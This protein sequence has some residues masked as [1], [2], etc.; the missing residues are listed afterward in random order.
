M[1][2]G[3]IVLLLWTFLIVAVAVLMLGFFGRD[4]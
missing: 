2:G 4:E 1:S 3:A